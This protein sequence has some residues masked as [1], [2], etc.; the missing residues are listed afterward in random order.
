MP[1]LIPVPRAERSAGIDIARGLALLGIIVVNARSFF[2]PLGWE[3]EIGP[4]HDGLQRSSLDW[5]VYDAVDVL[6]NY[7]FI[8]VFSLLFGFGLAQQAARCAAAGRSRWRMGL[9]RLGL[10]LAIGL[11]HGLLVW[12]GDILTLYSIVGTV[13]LACIGLDDR[14]LRRVTMGVVALILLVTVANAGM[15]WAFVGAAADH[16][17]VAVV[18]EHPLRGVDAMTDAGFDISSPTWIEAEVLAFRQGPWLDAAAFRAVSYALSLLFAPISYGWQPLLMMLVGVWAQRTRLFAPE[19]SSRRRLLAVRLIAAGLPCAVAAVLP[20]WFL[21]RESPAATALSTLALQLSALLLPVGYA[22]LAVEFGPRLP[23]VLRAP[24]QAAGS[25]GLTVYLCES[26]VCTGI[27]SWWGLAR[28]GTMTDAQFTAMVIG[29]WAGL[30]VAALAWTRVFGSG[31]TERLW[32]W[33]TYG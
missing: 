17:A 26:L 16:G 14:W 31:P 9:R 22:C 15:Q 8:S 10:L 29:V 3:A 33:G 4:L 32:R 11:L 5:A 1:S 21:G 28:F 25:I 6:A 30:M 18:A 23:T 20:W 24:I 7:K 2:L 13:V 27:A 12:A 19:S